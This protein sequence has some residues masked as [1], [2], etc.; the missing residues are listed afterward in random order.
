[1]TDQPAGKPDAPKPS[2]SPAEK[3]AESPKP[4][5]PSPKGVPPPAATKPE[6]TPSPPADPKKAESP[7][8][9]APKTEK[10]ATLKPD[11]KPFPWPIL[12]ALAAPLASA[13]LL[14]WLWSQEDLYTLGR[15]GWICL[16]VVLPGFGVM[17][18]LGSVA[19]TRRRP[20]LSSLALLLAI[21]TIL[22]CVWGFRIVTEAGWLD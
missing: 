19:Q 1:M 15:T 16:S 4:L 5:A 2:P 18:I 6:K 13:G 10:V 9:K 20:I 17:T 21:A 14:A 7:A 8:R 11:R 12:L 22:A 3:K